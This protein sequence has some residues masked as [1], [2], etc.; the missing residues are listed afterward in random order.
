MCNCEWIGII[1]FEVASININT[2]KRV[3]KYGS[4]NRASASRYLCPRISTRVLYISGRRTMNQSIVF[5][6]FASLWCL[7]LILS[8]NWHSKNRNLNF[9]NAYLGKKTGSPAATYPIFC[10]ITLYLTVVMVISH[11]IRISQKNLLPWAVNWALRF[12]FAPPLVENYG[13][14]RAQSCKYH[15]YD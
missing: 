13:I 10:F 7:A 4:F 15:T 14:P 8:R 11:K 9:N 12:D 2:I 5:A 6:L 3:I 1:K